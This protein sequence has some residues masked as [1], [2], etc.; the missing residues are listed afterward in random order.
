MLVT[1]WA[2]GSETE[3]PGDPSQRAL[4]EFV[5]TRAL[6]IESP[7]S[8]D[9]SFLPR[10]AATESIGP[11]ETAAHAALWHT[12]F[13]GALLSVGRIRSA[14]P[15]ALHYN[16]YLDVAVI[17]GCDSLDYAGRMCQD[18]C[19][20]P[21]EALSGAL[22]AHPG[23]A[24]LRA[25]PILGALVDTSRSRVGAFRDAH[26]A[27]ASKASMWKARYCRP[28][29]QTLAELR[30]VLAMQATQALD[31]VRLGRAIGRYLNA[32]PA[33]DHTE[34]PSTTETIDYLLT[35]LEQFNF[36]GSVEL[37]A[38]RQLLLFCP[39]RTGWF[40]LALM[41]GSAEAGRSTPY[42]L[43]SAVVLTI[44]NGGV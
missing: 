18:L 4:Q 20:L 40:L 33:V 21:G 37:S 30:V 27:A 28:E 8:A 15:M 44:G 31:R 13:R 11:S 23:P 16:P 3:Q 1:A 42:E 38:D 32:R 2:C 26:P 35:H 34:R 9:L 22:P 10:S 41:T 5:L 29:W 39:K 14:A 17:Q 36:V 24:W 43:L 19:A 7:E 12:F 6:L 25:P